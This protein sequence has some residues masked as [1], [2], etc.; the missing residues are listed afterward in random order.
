[1]QAWIRV[2]LL[3]ALLAPATPGEVVV[4]TV[5]NQPVQVSLEMTGFV[6]DNKPD[7]EHT[8]ML[9]VLREEVIVSV[10]WTDNLPAIPGS[11]SAKSYEK[12]P[13]YKAFAVNGVACCQYDV[14]FLD[15][16]LMTTWR[17]WPATP[18]LAFEIHVGIVGTT[19]GTHATSTFTKNDFVRIVSSWHTK[20]HIDPSSLRL[21]PEVYAFRDE[22]ATAGGDPLAWVTKQCEAHK[23]DWCVQFYLGVLGRQMKKPESTVQ[24]YSRAADLLAASANRS[25]KQTRAMIEA[26]DGA[27][28]ALESQKKF[29]DAV[30]LCSRVVGAVKAGDA[31]DLLRFRESALYRLACCHAMASHLDKAF[32]SLRQAI[33]E[34]PDYRKSAATDELLAPLRKRPEFKTLVGS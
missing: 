14:K 23:N 31:A 18:E 33:H 13:G 8:V 29:A 4:A 20:G 28:A 17:A 15:S 12:E 10:T 5:P 32:E 26:L 7:D 1:M 30:P 24:G 9:G 2:L 21:P 27:S 6:A 19:K 16:V 3:S 11:E 34:H 25:P 22:T